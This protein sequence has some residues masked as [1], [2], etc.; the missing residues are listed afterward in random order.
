L[1][2]NNAGDAFYQAVPALKRTADMFGDTA[3]VV[4][5][6]AYR[7][8]R[9]KRRYRGRG[10]YYAGQVAGRGAYGWKDLRRGIKAS[11]QWA[12]KNQKTLRTVAGIG[13]SFV[14]GGT[15]ALAAADRVLATGVGSKVGNL[16]EGRGA[17]NS[18]FPM[19]SSHPLTEF[20]SVKSEHGNIIVTG[21]EKVADIFGN[22]FVRDS[23]GNV[24]GT[25]AE[26]TAKAVPFT[27]FVIQCTPGNFQQFPKLAQ[28]AANYKEYEWVQLV[29]TYKSTIPDN[30][31]TSEVNT[32]KVIMAPEYNLDN[33]VWT[34]FGEMN[35]QEQKV[36]GGV[37]GNDANHSLGVEC[38]PRMLTTKGLK[39]VRTRGLTPAEDVTNFDLA[40]VSFGMFGTS[41]NL[42]QK[43][44]GELW[45]YYRVHFKT[46][47]QYSM[48]GYNIPQ[49]IKVNNFQGSTAGHLTW[50]AAGTNDVVAIW[51]SLFNFYQTGISR[52]LCFNNIDF[53]LSTKQSRWDTNGNINLLDDDNPDKRLLITGNE[54]VMDGLLVTITFPST[55]KG[56]YEIELQVDGTYLIPSDSSVN[57]ND[58]M[59][60]MGGVP[61][62]GEKFIPVST[63][64]TCITNSD[65]PEINN[66]PQK[67]VHMNL[68]STKTSIRVHVHLEQATS[69]DDN[70]VTI[71]VPLCVQNPNTLSAGDA[72]I[73]PPQPANKSWSGDVTYRSTCINIKQYNSFQRLGPSGLPYQDSISKEL[74]V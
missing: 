56:N 5:R 15:A 13:A 14:P 12:R 62:S 68:S 4:G 52:D 65:F 30:Y 46:H 22:D 57:P 47:R 40:R 69:T 34:T 9:R 59:D 27:S 6:G 58:I 35:S 67:Y 17:Y 28:H 37:T 3:G 72:T 32:G 10:A 66:R 45:V 39:N 61:P 42:C 24:I 38:D 7:R 43:M 31:Q 55:L 1:R 49:S 20:D 2:Y 21:R 71:G 33:K 48:L 54:L 16:I 51:D 25:L 29:F 23:S 53:E 8:Y 41:A 60:T 36:V 50:D 44:I 64:G 18:L 26:G 70:T 11:S 74:I 63:E 73:F 19:N